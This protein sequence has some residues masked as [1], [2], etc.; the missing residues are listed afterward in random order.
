[1]N[2][3]SFIGACAAA[4]AHA[5]SLSS[6]VRAEAG[7]S[8]KATTTTAAAAAVIKR[9]CGIFFLPSTEQTHYLPAGVTSKGRDLGIFEALVSTRKSRF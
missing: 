7:D 9:I 6:Q 4:A 5:A 3:S 8:A 1:M 2:W